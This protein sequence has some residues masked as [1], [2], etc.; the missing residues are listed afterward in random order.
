MKILRRNYR[1]SE[2][3]IFIRCFFKL[4]LSYRKII[5]F[6][7][8]KISLIFKLKNNLGFPLHIHIE[9]TNNCNY[10][11]IKCDRFSKI[12]ADNESIGSESNMP[13]E[14]YRQIIDDIGDTL[15]SLRLWHLGEPLLN[16]DLF[17]MIKYSKRKNIIVAVSSNLSLLTQEGAEKFV[18]SGLDY[19]IVSLDGASAETYNLYHG[20]AY[21]DKVVRNIKILVEAKK[22]FRSH[23]PFIELQFIVMRENEKEIDKV[24]KLASQLAVDK[25]TYLKVYTDRIDFDKFKGFGGT[26]DILP[27]N[28]DLCFN[29]EKLK[30]INFCQIPWE[31]ILIRHSG[32]ALPCVSDI[33]QQQKMGNLFHDGRYLGFKALW[34]NNN[35]CNFRR[36]VACN[37]NGIDICSHCGQ[38]NNNIED[39]IRFHEKV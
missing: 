18:D 31:G 35:Y 20:G 17:R 34:N 29:K 3:Y 27:K 11:C 9:P 25:M 15:I 39:Q 10:R 1:I 2:V 28:K 6:F 16:Q 21:F 30:C 26:R 12:Y 23:R 19:L 24:R 32:L 36:K 4:L 13:F 38:R 8:V 33:G 22:R 5:N 14:R 37:V 7:L